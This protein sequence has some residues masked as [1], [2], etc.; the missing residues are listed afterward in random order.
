MK[1]RSDYSGIFMGM[2]FG[3]L[4]GLVLFAVESTV[5]L[6]VN[7]QYFCDVIILTALIS[8]SMGALLGT[9]S[10]IMSPIVGSLGRI[11][12][13]DSRKESCMLLL[14]PLL[15]IIIQGG[16]IINYLFMFGRRISETPSILIDCLWALLCL[17]LFSLISRM[18]TRWPDLPRM[19]L[20]FGLLLTTFCVALLSIHYQK[21]YE[22]VYSHVIFQI[23]TLFIASVACFLL[24]FPVTDLMKRFLSRRSSARYIALKIFFSYMLFYILLFSS[25]WFLAEHRSRRIPVPGKLPGKDRPNVILIVLD[26]VRSDHLSCYG[27]NRKTSPQLDDFSQSS[28]KFENCYSTANWTVPGHASIFTGRYSISHGAHKAIG[29]SLLKDER[30]NPFF[31]FPLGNEE[32]TLAEVLHE[33]GY[34]TAAVVSNHTCVSGIFGLDQGFDYF[35]NSPPFRYKPVTYTILMKSNLLQNRVRPYLSPFRIAK[36][37]NDKVFRWINIHSDTPFFMFINYMDA[38]DPYIPPPEYQ[39][40]F[41]GKIERFHVD[42]HLFGENHEEVSEEQIHH[43]ESQYDGEI[44]YLDENLGEL[45]V[46]LKSKGLYERS[47]I[48]ITSDHGEYLGEKK[49]FGHSVG[50][51]EPVLRVPLI[52]HAPGNI[53][54]DVDTHKP[55]QTIDIM[56]TILKIL[57]I[58]IPGGVQGG[59]LI[60]EIRHPIISE[61]Y[62]GPNY[63]NT[64]NG[65]FYERLTSLIEENYKFI[66][67]ESNRHEMYDILKDSDEVNNLIEA[68]KEKSNNLLT[69]IEDWKHSVEV[70]DLDQESLPDLNE[71]TL[72]D[73]RA[74]GYIR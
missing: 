55:V 27:Y 65:R 45:F 53:D 25:Y 20:I 44:A 14:I 35:Y 21:P 38:H 32:V 63:K 60:Q 19:K 52:I 6:L 72:R 37:I 68:D 17:F 43:L 33:Q 54:W 26:T 18:Q 1:T 42:I 11:L 8:A 48:V 41:P 46:W 23:F 64:Y 36:D 34:R 66:F 10:W 30:I 12:L 57:D 13:S 24:S 71:A 40:M 69:A 70:K 51:Y 31:S 2:F 5:A 61:H 15:I 58:P 9:L 62:V 3:V 73:L 59:A 22:V 74:L 4:C 7:D 28:M 67:S 29:D 47:I 16:I 39:R 56:P 49:L 50:L